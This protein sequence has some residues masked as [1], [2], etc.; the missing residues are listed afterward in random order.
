M[1]QVKGTGQARIF[2]SPLLEF[3]TKTSPT[4]TLVVYLPI[5]AW[6]VYWYVSNYSQSLT[7]TAAIFFGGY[8]FWTL[9]EYLMHRYIFHFISDSPVAKRFHYLVH[10][11]HHEYPRDHERLFMP[12]VPGL[13]ILSVI[14]SL[15]YLLLGH[16]TFIF[17]PGMLVGYLTYAFIHYSMHRFQPPKNL[18]FLWKH[19]N[20]H[21]FKYTDR[22]FGVSSPLWD[23]IFGTMPPREQ[24]RK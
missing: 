22:A 1:N 6:L 17:L 12:P 24:E 19:H 20:M 4:I 23:Y 3:L 16:Y 18:R 14:F 11:V 21:H 10:G 8:L 5:V 2:K 15:Q 13:L 7:T 9:F